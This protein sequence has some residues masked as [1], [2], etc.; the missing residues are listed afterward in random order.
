MHWDQIQHEWRQS[1]VN[2]LKDRY[3]LTEAE[4]LMKVDKWLQWLTIGAPTA[5]VPADNEGPPTGERSIAL[6][7]GAS[8]Q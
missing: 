2:K 6:E 3:S 1:L 5:G 8:S 7:A 4:A